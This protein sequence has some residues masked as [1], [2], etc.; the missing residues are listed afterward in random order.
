MRGGNCELTTSD[1]DSFFYVWKSEFLEEVNRTTLRLREDGTVDRSFVKAGFVFGRYPSPLFFDG[2][3]ETAR[4]DGSVLRKARRDPRVARTTWVPWENDTWLRA[5]YSQ[6]GR[7]KL[8]VEGTDRPPEALRGLAKVP[9]LLLNRAHINKVE[10]VPSTGTLVVSGP[11]CPMEGRFA[12]ALNGDTS[13]FYFTRDPSFAEDMA[14]RSPSMLPTFSLDGW[15]RIAPNQPTKFTDGLVFAARRTES[16]WLSGPTGGRPTIIF[17]GQ[18]YF[19]FSWEGAIFRRET[20]SSPW[21]LLLDLEVS[22]HDP[23]EISMSDAVYVSVPV[24]RNDEKARVIRLYEGTASELDLASIVGGRVTDIR[25]Q[26]DGRG[27]VWIRA[28]ATTGPNGRVERFYLTN[29]PGQAF[30]CGQLFGN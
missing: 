29:A 4:W 16:S 18:D 19:A 13:D 9:N 22:M 25:L 17:D 23:A 1:V 7:V 3:A 6:E 26:G 12:C 2:E 14:S 10:S 5:E 20:T 11:K 24:F 15:P 27:N 28:A 30:S 21:K 8:I